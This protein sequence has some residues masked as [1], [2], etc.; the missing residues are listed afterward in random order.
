MGVKGRR[1]GS[2][3]GVATIVGEEKH[4]I[5]ALGLRLARLKSP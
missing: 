4:N 3:G 5:A 1:G 2:M